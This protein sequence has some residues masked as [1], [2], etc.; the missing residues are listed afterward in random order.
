MKVINTVTDI[1]GGSV[2]AGDTLEYT[3]I[4][5]N[6]GSDISINTAIYDTLAFNVNY[7]P[8][9]VRIV[10]GPNVGTKTD[11]SGDDQADYNSATRSLL[12]RIGTGANA[13]TGG[14][15]VNSPTGIDSS[16]VKF[17]VTTTTECVKLMCDNQSQ[18]RSYMKGQGQIS[19]NYLVGGS[20]PDA[21]DANGCPV[22]GTTSTSISIGVCP[23]TVSSSNS[24]IC[25][26]DS[27]KLYAPFANDAI[28]SWTG[29]GGYTSSAQNPVRLNATSA[30]AGVY[31]VT[32]SF[33]GSACTQSSPSTVVVNALPTPSIA[34]T[35]A[36]CTI[37][38]S[39]ILNGGSANLTASGGVSYA[40]STTQSLTSITVSP[41]ISTTYTVT[42]TNSN[43]CI[44]TANKTITVEKFWPTSA[45][46]DTWIPPAWAPST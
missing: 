7:V 35:D 19:G 29:P 24:P 43:G 38:D 41:S 1:N 32:I 13:T 37:N 46:P 40:W 30:M 26:N 27:I 9:S 4:A 22:K 45:Q 28:Y 10:T 12:I 18:N 8:G 31:T 17:R 44:A 5:K 20:N 15:V 39:K 3:F 34:E 11:A 16:V 21:V 25:V 6:L 33:P 14:S 2:A 42:A 36:S 23:A